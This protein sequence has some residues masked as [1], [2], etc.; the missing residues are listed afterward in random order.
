M[1]SS[2]N[3]PQIFAVKH[4]P[5][6]QDAKKALSIDSLFLTEDSDGEEN[7]EKFLA[8]FWGQ[9]I[10]EI[11]PY[12]GVETKSNPVYFMHVFLFFH[13]CGL[14]PPVWVL[15][16]L[17]NGFIAYLMSKGGKSL[18][19]LLGLKRKKGQTPVFK[20][21]ANIYKE[22]H[23][24]SEIGRLTLLGVSAENAAYMVLR[25]LQENAIVCPT[26]E[27]LAER[28]TKRGW[29]KFFQGIKECFLEIPDDMK[30]AIIA[31]Y[32]EDSIPT[33]LKRQF[34]V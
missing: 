23:M 4:L 10:E 5:Q 20:E 2:E 1:S 33:K 14:Y 11:F 15:N 28:Y 34:Q 21:F 22:T 24:M 26:S 7:E 3:V 27:T 29:G 9:L 18:D 13:F 16:W 30:K 32:P 17:K 19:S 12:D 25:R 31:Q 6:N 8:V